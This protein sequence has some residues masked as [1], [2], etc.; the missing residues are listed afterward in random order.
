MWSDQG[1]AK[2]HHAS[3]LNSVPEVP[4]GEP[5][6]SV[7][8]TVAVLSLSHP[9]P[10]AYDNTKV[11]MLRDFLEFFRRPCTEQTVN[12]DFPNELL[13]IFQHEISF[14]IFPQSMIC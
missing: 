4:E 1:F 11:C 7:S 2:G 14:A 3:G 12:F 5:Y 9:T 8:F 6:H 13:D 10:I